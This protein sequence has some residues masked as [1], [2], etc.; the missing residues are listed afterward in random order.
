VIAQGSKKPLESQ[1]SLGRCR[2]QTASRPCVCGQIGLS[3]GMNQGRY[4]CN[5]RCWFRGSLRRNLHKKSC[6]EQAAIFASRADACW[7]SYWTNKFTAFGAM[8]R[9]LGQGAQNRNIT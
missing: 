9:L 8:W 5:D 7:G 6:L 4:P 1:P 2:L 3:K